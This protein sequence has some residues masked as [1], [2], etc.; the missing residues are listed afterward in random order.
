M[1]VPATR[2]LLVDDNPG[3]LEM[4]VDLLQRDFVIAG[5]CSRGAAVLAEFAEVNPDITLLDVSLAT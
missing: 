5:T 2:L 4:L 1:T 3:T